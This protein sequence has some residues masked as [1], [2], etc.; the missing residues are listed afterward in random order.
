MKW[1]RLP[2]ASIA[3][4]P[5]FR[6]LT[7][8]YRSPEDICVVDSEAL[9]VY[10][11]TGLRS[12]RLEPAV[13]EITLREDVVFQIVPLSPRRLDLLLETIDALRD[14]LS[15]ACLRLCVAESISVRGSFVEEIGGETRENPTATLH[16]V[17]V[18]QGKDRSSP[19]PTELLFRLADIEDDVPRFMGNWLDAAERLRPIR[20]LYLSARYADMPFLDSKFLSLAQAVE[21][22]HRRFRSG[23]YLDADIFREDVL[24]PLLQAIPGGVE[25]PI[26]DVIRGRLQYLNE[27]SL[28][29]RLKR[30]LPSGKVQL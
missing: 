24:A 26:R 3:T 29:K 12:V 17:P 23:S 28:R 14:F 21:A 7:A 27:Y 11:K 6:E 15:V 18:L 13:D 10:I 20:A 5:P 8:D 16:G 4:E 22:Y 2:S 19:H 30:G 1:P 9:S 25:R